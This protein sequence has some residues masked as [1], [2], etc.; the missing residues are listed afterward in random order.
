MEY[1]K[2]GRTGFDV[3]A[4]SLGMVLPLVLLSF[5]LPFYRARLLSFLN[6]PQPGPSPGATAA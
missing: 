5:L 3:S 1:R 4:I 2:L 6:L